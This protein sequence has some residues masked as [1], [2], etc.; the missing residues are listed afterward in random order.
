DS[1]RCLRIL[2][3]SNEHLS[4]H[5][6]PC[7]MYFGSI[8]F[9]DLKIFISWHI[10]LWVAEVF[11]KPISGKSMELV[12]EEYLLNDIIEINLV[13]VHTRGSTGNIKLCN[14][15][16]LLRDLFFKQVEKEEFVCAKRLYDIP[17]IDIHRRVCIH[18]LDEEYA[19]QVMSNRSSQSPPLKRSLIIDYKEV[20]PSLNMRLLR[21][22]KSNNRAL[23]YGEISSV[24][25]N[26]WFVN[27]QYLAFRVDWMSISDY[28]S[29]IHLHGNLQTLV[30]YGAWNTKAPPKIWKMHQLKHIKF[31]M[32]DLTN[33]KMDER[34]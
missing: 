8:F 14:L 22:L 3:M 7:F 2:N 15:H 24:G 32:L 31:V 20:F 17:Q 11:L 25:A 19:P 9:K 10:K 6:K 30:V 16:D 12:V 28:L 34:D 29:S 23:H 5:L 33:P 1:E 27:L 18:E 21:I 13:L 26:F 4:V